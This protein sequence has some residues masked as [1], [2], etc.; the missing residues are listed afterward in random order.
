MIFE[1]DSPV[2]IESKNDHLWLL[3]ICNVLKTL[4]AMLP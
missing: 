4:D 1:I 2:L 3:L